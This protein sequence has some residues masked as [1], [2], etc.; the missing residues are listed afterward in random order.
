MELIW[1]SSLRNGLSLQ[2]TSDLEWKQTEFVR[3][4]FYGQNTT[5]PSEFHSSLIYST[6]FL[7][8]SNYA[9]EEIY[10]ISRFYGD[11]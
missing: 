8:S 5:F 10:N 2:D 1:G 6:P 3:F 9:N 11:F 7:S 4:L